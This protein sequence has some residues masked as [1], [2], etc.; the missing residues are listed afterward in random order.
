M[1]DL[2]VDRERCIR[3]GACISACGRGVFADD[4]EGGPKVPPQN[5]AL[6]NLC[7]HC[8][9]VCPTGAV[10]S[11]GYGGEK[12]IPLDFAPQTD[13]QGAKRFLL[14]CRSMRRYKEEAVPRHEILELLDIARKAPTASNMQAL[15]WLAIDDK[16]KMRRF[17]ALTMEWFDTVVRRDPLMSKRYNVDNLMARYKTGYDPILRG[18]PC[19]VLVLTGQEAPYGPADASIALTYFCL[20]ANARNIGSCWCGFGMS[21]LK[22]YKPLRE[23]MGLDEATVV[24][25]MAF[26]GYP[27]LTYHAIPPRKPLTVSWL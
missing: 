15:R 18:A 13:F 16:E 8:S 14:S 4:G 6:C 11:P 22:N 20:A 12:A 9:A 27:T 21:A 7:G 26:F 2:V 25:T 24:Q 5:E 10:V 23:F 19:A 3:C 17:T 1:F